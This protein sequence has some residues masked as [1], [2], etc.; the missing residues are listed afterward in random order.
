MKNVLLTLALTGFGLTSAFAQDGFVGSSAN[1]KNAKNYSIC[2]KGSKYTPCNPNVTKS[3]IGRQTVT[4][5]S[6]IKME[7][8]YYHMG[9]TTSNARFRGRIRVSY[10][11][12]HAPYLGKSSMANDGVQKNKARN[13][14]TNNGEYD[15]PPNDGQ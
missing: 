9:Y 3:D 6:G 7:S 4:A 13:K 2:L 15:L 8:N 5:S 1:S 11:D 14:N 12:P 10:D